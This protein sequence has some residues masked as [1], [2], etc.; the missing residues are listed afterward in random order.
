MHKSFARLN[1]RSLHSLPMLSLSLYCIIVYWPL[2]GEGGKGSEG[3]LAD[4]RD[5][6]N[7]NALCVRFINFRARARF[8][9]LPCAAAG[10][11][12]FAAQPQRER[13]SSN[14]NSTK[15]TNKHP[16]LPTRGVQSNGEGAGRHYCNI[17]I[18]FVINFLIK[19]QNNYSL[20]R[21]LLLGAP[22]SCDG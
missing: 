10:A 19:F 5:S 15:G 8:L 2:Q 22:R 18:F 11:Q 7:F 20:Q 3:T 17:V 13:S 1:E 16:A 12:L 14:N 4:R 9:L 6:A 21:K